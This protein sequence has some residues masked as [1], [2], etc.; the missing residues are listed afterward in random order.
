MKEIYEKTI[1]LLKDDGQENNN[2]LDSIFKIGQKLEE[3]LLLKIYLKIF[4]RVLKGK[5]KYDVNR[6]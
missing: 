2:I 1:E 4:Q 6:K 3:L 5:R